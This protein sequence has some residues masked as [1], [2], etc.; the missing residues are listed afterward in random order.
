MTR[1]NY[2]YLFLLILI[3]SVE[4][5]SQNDK[6]FYHPLTNSL[7]LSLKGGTNYPLTDYE[8][9]GLGWLF[10][11]GLEY[12]LPTNSKSIF[13]FGINGG[14]QNVL[15]DTNYLGLPGTFN[16]QILRGGIEVIYSYAVNE[17]FYPFV[18]V[19]G[20]Y[21][22]YEFESENVK[23][24][25]YNNKSELY[26]YSNGGKKNSIVVDANA[27]IMFNV[28]KDITLNIGL[29]YHYILDD[30][31]DAIAVGDFK[32]FYLSGNVGI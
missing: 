19:G 10:S 16:T 31:I 5:Y 26:N 21:Y 28:A 23:S 25:F 9:P 27:G 13:G 15:G 3:S 20:S 11:G 22:L 18:S 29:G 30:N 32:D 14:M 1:K 2:L 17:D 24:R 12:Y 8:N 4:L 7:E 6:Q